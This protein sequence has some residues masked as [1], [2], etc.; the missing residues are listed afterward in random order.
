M[1]NRRDI[2]YYDDLARERLIYFNGEYYKMREEF[3]LGTPYTVPRF[4][5]DPYGPWRMARPVQHPMRYWTDLDY[6]Y[7]HRVR[8]AVTRFKQHYVKDGYDTQIDGLMIAPLGA[9]VQVKHI[10]AITINFGDKNFNYSVEVTT[11]KVYRID[12]LSDGTL[13]TIIGK[14]SDSK[15]LAG[16]DYRG[17]DIYYVLLTVDCSSDFGSN[18]RYVDS[19]DIRYICALSDLQTNTSVTNTYIGLEEPD[20]D[21]YGGWYNPL[22]REY[23]LFHNG[24]WYTMPEKPTDA[25]EGKFYSYDVDKMEWILKDIPPIP[26]MYH[27]GQ[28]WTFNDV[29]GYWELEYVAP[30][31]TT[32]LVYP[33]LTNE[34]LIEDYYIPPCNI[35]DYDISNDEEAY[36]NLY[37]KVWKTRQIQPEP[38]G[39]GLVYEFDHKEE[40]WVG[41][42]PN[43]L[44]VGE[45]QIEW[46]DFNTRQWIF[47][48]PVEPNVNE[49]P[50]YYAW[51]YYTEGR[52]VYMR[53]ELTYNEK[54]NTWSLEATKIFDKPK[55]SCKEGYFWRYYP[56][57]NQWFQ[58]PISDVSRNLPMNINGEVANRDYEYPIYRNT[59]SALIIDRRFS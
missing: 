9:T 51:V 33:E 45:G 3:L 49:F 2:R 30:R 50:D 18:L 8:E 52:M 20:S 43:E 10:P 39:E 40:C 4:Q 34:A 59:N 41:V 16:V 6:R 21:E 35:S 55:E 54:D 17:K 57:Y 5:W 24:K 42:R 47:G 29:Q 53:K 7:Q 38:P 26:S 58:T 37:Y 22:T 14:I 28:I 19:R 12:Y 23:K 11:D 15:T 27:R 25:P 46:Y 31:P 32:G 13:Y 48:T 1:K 56:S 44:I 36:W